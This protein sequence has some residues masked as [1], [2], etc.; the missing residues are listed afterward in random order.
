MGANLFL[1]KRNYIVFVFSGANLNDHIF[2]HASL[3][4]CDVCIL[5]SRA[6]VDECVKYRMKQGRLAGAIFSTDYRYWMCDSQF[7]V[8]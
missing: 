6:S 8:A 5:I 2:D 7:A 3:R 4:A 1:V